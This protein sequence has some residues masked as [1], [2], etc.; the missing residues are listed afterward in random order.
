MSNEAEKRRG[1]YESLRDAK[2]PPE[3]TRQVQKRKPICRHCLK[4]VDF[5]RVH[6]RFVAFEVGSTTMHLCSALEIPSTIDEGRVGG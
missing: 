5:S 1:E 2:N 3:N 6:G 4:P